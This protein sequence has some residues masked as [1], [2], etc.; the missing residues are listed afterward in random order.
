MPALKE[1]TTYLDE[2]LELDRFPHDPS[3]NGLQFQG[4]N[5]VRKA[6]F[7]VDASEAAMTIA[8]D[9]EA[10]FLFVHHGISWGSGLRR[11]TGGCAERIKILAK[12]N[13]SLYAAHLPL[14][15]NEMLGHNAL[16]AQMAEL[17]SEAGLLCFKVPP[18]GIRGHQ[19]MC[20]HSLLG[21]VSFPSW[22]KLTLL[23]S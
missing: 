5:Q 3:N 13:I 18:Q 2:L 9:L 23:T 8:A 7:A 15:A 11:I 12:D 21:G 4:N 22:D 17:E 6:V 14:D 1:L 10:D 16:L 19:S 20:G